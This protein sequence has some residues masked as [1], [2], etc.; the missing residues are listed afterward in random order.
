MNIYDMSKVNRRKQNNSNGPVWFVLFLTLTLV[1]AIG[2]NGRISFS[3]WF[4]LKA[5]AAGTGIYIAG[6][7]FLR[8]IERHRLAGSSMK[9]IDKMTGE[10]F[11]KYLGIL[12]EKAGYKVEYTPGTMDFGA[13]LIVTKN[14]KKTVVQAKRYRHQVG[15]AAVQQALSGKG[16]YKADLCMVVTNSEF[17]HAAK[18]LAKRADVLLVNRWKLGTSSMYP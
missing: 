6:L 7:L 4:Y 16:Y 9:Q 5:L 15:E 3:P 17:T 2:I 10:D 13:D 18:E 12:Y 1:A 8:L 11:E 14:G